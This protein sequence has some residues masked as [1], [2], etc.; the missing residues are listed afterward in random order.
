MGRNMSK[1]ADWKIL[2]YNPFQGDETDI[3]LLSDRMVVTRRAHKCNIC[4]EDFPAGSRARARREVNREE[5]KTMTFYFCPLC[6]EAMAK[7][8]SDDD[9]AGRAIEERTSMGMDRAGARP[10]QPPISA[11]E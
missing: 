6:C 9:D 11:E 2:S 7:A 3:R 4:W 10:D 5:H 1:T 8:M